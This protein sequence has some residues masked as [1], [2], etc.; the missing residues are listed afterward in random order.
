MTEMLYLTKRI[1]NVKNSDSKDSLYALEF[2]IDVSTS[3]KDRGSDVITKDFIYKLAKDYSENTTY[4]LNHNLDRP[5][6]KILNSKA[7]ELDDGEYAVRLHVGISKE[8]QKI[9]NLIRDGTLNKASIGFIPDYK[10]AV[11]DSESDT[12]F[13]YDGEGY[14]ASSVSVPMNKQT[15]NIR[16]V[17]SIRDDLIAKSLKKDNEGD[18]DMDEEELKAIISSTV[19]TAVEKTADELKIKTAEVLE[20]SDAKYQ[21][22]LE[23]QKKSYEDKIRELEEERKSYRQTSAMEEDNMIKDKY[24]LMDEKKALDASFKEIGQLFKDGDRFS[25][26][27]ILPKKSFARRMM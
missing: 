11:Y 14:E 22:M 25:I 4:L 21:K 10:S 18:I 9:A 19:Q 17:K 12:F 13:M 23:E 26:K 8:E 16:I 27:I 24:F 7:V 15:G 5:I 1:K 2:E 6:G 20:E 3:H